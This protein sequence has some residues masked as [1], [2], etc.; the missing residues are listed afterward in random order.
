MR[1]N[2]KPEVWSLAVDAPSQSQEFLGE[3]FLRMIVSTC[4][5]TELENARS[6]LLEGTAFCRH[7]LGCMKHSTD[8]WAARCPG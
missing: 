8:N 5:M 4:S 6:K 7:C 1:F 2:G 3:L